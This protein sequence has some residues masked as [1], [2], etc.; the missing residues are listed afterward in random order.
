MRPTEIRR[1]PITQEANVIVP[2]IEVP[3]MRQ[4][5][6]LISGT[7]DVLIGESVMPDGVGPNRTYKLAPFPPATTIKFPLGPEQWLIAA[8]SIG[9]Q[10]LTV[11]IEYLP[12]PAGYTTERY[13]PPALELPSKESPTRELLPGPVYDALV[14]RG[15][16]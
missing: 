9:S 6:V 7:S 15:E 4:V 11:I 2:A 8:V 10:A 5:Q 12:L 3:L 1:V 16:L 13:L 14:R